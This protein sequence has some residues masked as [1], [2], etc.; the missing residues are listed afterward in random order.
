MKANE[1]MIGDWVKVVSC[2]LPLKV[3]S[4]EDGKIGLCHSVLWNNSIG[5]TRIDVPSSTYEV[6]VDPIPLT[7]EILQKNFPEFEQGYTVGWF[8]NNV[9]YQIEWYGDLEDN[10]II[11]KHVGSVH[12][13]Q[14]ILR[15]VGSRKEIAL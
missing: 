9:G 15:L 4:V 11:M 7:D 6:D 8:P 5:W 1:L 13:L 2:P 3:R 10:E 12:Q 14:H